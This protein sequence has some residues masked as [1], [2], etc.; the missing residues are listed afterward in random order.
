MGGESGGGGHTPYEAPDSLKAAQQLRAIGLISLGPIKGIERGKEWQNVFFD[1]T[2]IQNSN[3]EFNFKNTEIQFTTGTQDQLPLQGFEMSEREVPVNT[4]VKQVRPLTRTV[5][6]PDITRLRITLGVTALFSQNDEGDT[7]GTAVDFDVLINDR[8]RADYRIEGKS[9]SRFFRS[10]IIDNL[11]P[12]PFT[13]TV[14]RRT[15][16]S[17]SQRLQNGTV[18]A[19]YTE[20]IDT[21]LNYPNMALVGIKTDSR[22]NPNFPNIN[23]L[24]KGRLVKI[25]ANY[26]PINRTYAA[27]LWRGDFKLD[28]TNNP[29]WIF[30]DLVTNK[31]VGLGSRLGEF[32]VDKFQLYQIAQYCDQLVPDGYGGQEPRMTANL[33]ITTQRSAYDVLSDMASVFRAM[34]VWNGLQLSATQDRPEDPVC[35]YTQA[36]V[37]DGKF[38]RQYVPMKAIFTAVEVEY[39]DKRNR[40]Q[41]TIEYVADDDLIRRYGYNVKKIVAFACTSRG[42]ARRYGKWVLETSRLEQ[43]TISFAVGREGL[44]HLPGDIIEVADNE[45]ANA[46]LGGRIVAV[47]NRQITLDRPV[48]YTE[49]SYLCYVDLYSKG[50]SLKRIKVRSVS[51]EKPNEI[52]LEETPVGLKASDVWTLQ[53]AQLRTQRYRAISVSENEDGSYGI[54]ALQHEAQKHAIVDEGANFESVNYSRHLG[55]APVSAAEIQADHRGI[56]LSFNPPHFVG[57][58]LLFQVTLYRDG[59]FYQVFEDLNEPNLAFQGLPNGEYVAE[60]RAKNY[61][62]QLS[63]AVTKAFNIQ[64]A[65]SQLVTVSK[66]FG[67]GLHWKN[68]IYANPNSAIEIWVSRDNVFQ[69]ARKLTALA[70]PT[71]SYTFDG[72]GVNESYYFWAR[73]VDTLNGNAGEFTQPVLGTTESS[74][75]KLT[76]YLNG[77]IT[78]ANLSADLIAGF[79]A[80]I[81]QA[82]GEE[83]QQRQSAVGN[84][85][86]QVTR[87]QATN[88]QQNNAEI[89]RVSRAVAD[90]NG[91]VSATHTIKTQTIAGGRTAIA[92]IAIGTQADNRTAESSVIVMA[93]KFSVVKNAQDGRAVPMFS[94]VDNKV[95]INGDLIARGSISGDKVQANT[96]ID[97]PV[98]QGGSL[99]GNTISGATINGGVIK[100]TH[101]E[102]VTG[103]F[104]GELEVTQL[105]SGGIFQRGI[106][107]I[108]VFRWRLNGRHYPKHQKPYVSTEPKN[109]WGTPSVDRLFG[110]Y[111]VR[112]RIAPAKTR[113]TLQLEYL[114]P[115]DDRSWKE[116]VRVGERGNAYN[117]AYTVISRYP[118]NIR[119][120]IVSGEGEIVEKLHFIKIAADTTLIVDFTLDISMHGITPADSYPVAWTLAIDSYNPDTLS[121]TYPT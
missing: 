29:A 25:P 68:P 47:D 38:N 44:L 89:S 110:E 31:Q 71:N 116:S 75:E 27:G 16:D 55:L 104:S 23:F 65:I 78:K 42:Q 67:I 34:V 92:G 3:G 62:G 11:P 30:Y 26:D 107:D 6:D 121:A 82:V 57:Q 87:L 59:K 69:N 105:I 20:I 49:D 33:W 7:Y 51:A 4:E 14:R 93:D 41:K 28:W 119:A 24:L 12:V 61:A 91:K 102:G 43:C 95:A 100:G 114:G 8:F 111:R 32:G 10:Y 96:R 97:A 113:R 48:E 18:W 5:I 115:K 108:K 112:L 101:F 120:T 53:K 70:Y 106:V 85:Q 39:A 94:A 50:M 81:A 63:E 83:T 9:S 86:T 88:N 52:E 60:I 99:T 77:Q 118:E 13:I 45:Y 37:V 72:L 66:V 35:L 40:Y 90:L 21:K 117:K 58:G 98:I 54:T 17:T 79:N 109:T 19:S 64:F 1:H 73:M 46:Q 2:P 103:R 74:G 15:P 36:N 56:H 76:E 80:D 22:Y 84:L